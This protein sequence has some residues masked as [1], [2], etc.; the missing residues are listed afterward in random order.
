MVLHQTSHPQIV[1]AGGD[2]FEEQSL[3]Q[4]DGILAFAE[5][6]GGINLTAMKAVDGGLVKCPYRIHG[7][8]NPRKKTP[9]ERVGGAVWKDLDYLAAQ[10]C[11]RIGIHAP[12][13]IKGA[14]M[15][16]R[17]AVDWL[18]EHKGAVE[19]LTFVDL[20]DDYHN[21]FG[22]DSFNGS[23]AVSNPTPT[24][25]EAYLEDGFR[26]DLE[27]AFGPEYNEDGFPTFVVRG[28]DVKGK[29]EQ[30]IFFPVNL[31][32]AMF[33]VNL[34]PQAYAL[35]A[36]KSVDMMKFSAKSGLPLFDRVMAGAVSSWKLLADT[37]LLP[38]EKEAG[39]WFALAK[40]EL[41]F[42]GRVLMHYAIGGVYGSGK[43]DSPDIKRMCR[44]L[45]GCLD[46]F[47]AGLKNGVAMPIYYLPESFRTP[48]SY[49]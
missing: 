36:G 42:F 35:V 8:D 22:L 4:F 2:L 13:D 5:G 26:H 34:I 43:H 1:F 37:G 28:G 30:T 9:A 6:F 10:G 18:E 29:L 38:G 33:F 11:R 7:L 21:C 45:K 14:K 46:E 44:E 47:E 3:A 40:A 12:N 49:R 16:L 19:S 15:A 25:F 31:S 39:E 23:P 24:P 17:S 27:R 48:E 41:P 20:H 32:V